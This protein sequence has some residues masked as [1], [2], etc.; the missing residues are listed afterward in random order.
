MAVVYLAH[1]QDSHEHDVAIKVLSQESSLSQATITRFLKEGQA[2]SAIRHPNVI[3]LVEPPGRTEDGQVYL[4]MELLTG[5]PLSEII[6]EMT[7]AGQAFT[8][9]RLAPLILQICRALHATHKRKIV[10]RDMKPS[11][12]FC[13][14][15][16][17]DPWHI[18]VLDFGIAKVQSTGLSDD[19]IET[20]LTQDGVFVGTPHYAAPEIIE[21]RPEH[22]I[23]GRADIFSLGVMMY[24]CLTGTLPF[25]KFRKDTLTAL[26]KTAHERPESPRTRAP[27]RD[28]PP[29]VE[30]I[31][32]RAMELKVDERF[33]SVLDLAAAIRLTIRPSQ[34]AGRDNGS[35]FTPPSASSRGAEVT[36]LSALTSSIGAKSPASTPPSESAARIRAL[37]EQGTPLPPGVTSLEKLPEGPTSFQHVKPASAATPVI[38]AAL[39][40]AGLLL[41]LALILRETLAASYTPPA[42][43]NP[44][45][46][47]RPDS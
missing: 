14:E 25:E 22:T 26:Y 38:I 33:A 37:P 20:P 30:A 43:P 2:I 15:L 13:T 7:A 34:A 36:P 31:V 46:M 8:W 40:V 4:A 45:A 27:A 23:D 29:E 28:I 19:S 6:S 44:S 3:Q 41:I 5:K 18:K 42:K 39:M 1:A 11:N 17:D 10:H 16:D 24:Q 32:M 35:E 47:S 21:R 9:P 12:C